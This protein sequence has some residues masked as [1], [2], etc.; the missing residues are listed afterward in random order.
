MK[1]KSKLE[2]PT[3][4][5]PVKSDTDSDEDMDFP[6]DVIHVPHTSAEKI[7]R[8]D[9]GDMDAGDIVEPVHEPHIAEDDFPHDADADDK[10]DEEQQTLSSIWILMMRRRMQNPRNLKIHPKFVDHQELEEN[11]HR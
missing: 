11:Q 8:E 4:T 1:L 3:P 10:E 9:V 6:H 7:L 2:E 5:E